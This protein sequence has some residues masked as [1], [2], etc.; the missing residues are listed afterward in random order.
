ML[1]YSQDKGVMK[2]CDRAGLSRTPAWRC[3]FEACAEQGFSFDAWFFHHQLDEMAE[4]AAA[5]PQTQFILCHMGTPIG[6]G[7]PFAS[8]GHSARQRDH[9]RQTWQASMAR[10]AA[11]PNIAVKLSGFFMPVLGWGFHQ[12][13]TPVS[14]NEVVNCLGPF[15]AFVLEQFGAERCLFASNFPMDKVSLSLK[16]LYEV[17]WEL[18]ASYPEATRN[19]LFR[20]NARRLY[21][22]DVD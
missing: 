4:L 10:L 19:A 16:T 13:K 8:Y 14:V 2:F 20:E 12:R 17:Y 3:G 1:A 15:V 5:F 11:Y 21:R 18:V 6:V 9:I 22:I 7:G